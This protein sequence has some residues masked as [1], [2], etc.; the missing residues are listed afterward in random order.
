MILP[1]EPAPRGRDYASGIA[2]KYSKLR[3]DSTDELGVHTHYPTPLNVLSH[4]YEP[5]AT[6]AKRK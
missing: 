4:A 1:D 6:V 3:P 5:K 2:G